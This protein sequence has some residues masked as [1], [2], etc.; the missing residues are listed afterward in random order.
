MP[1]V[2]DAPAATTN[3]Q[4]AAA[5]LVTDAAAPASKEAAP[6]QPAADTAKAAAPADPAA[7]PAV[8][9]A[10]EAPK[11]EPVY[12]LKAPE[13][14]QG[15]VK[16]FADFAKAE[17]ISPAAAQKLLE[18]E[19]GQAKAIQ[20]A[21]V[22]QMRELSRTAWVEQVK[23]DKEIGGERFATSVETAKRFIGKFGS[24]ALKKALDDSGLGNHPELIRTFARA[25]AAMRDDALLTTSTAAPGPKTLAETLYPN[26]K[27][28]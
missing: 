28:G 13:G 26:M 23:A 8:D 16:A 2:A 17:G 10:K 14:Y 1:A 12:D 3:D 25:G 11:P 15:D 20:E 6:A 27:K 18:R 7:K 5:T 22:A 21:A 4:N 9:P 24:D 19:A